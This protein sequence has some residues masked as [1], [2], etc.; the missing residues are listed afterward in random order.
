MLALIGAL[1]ILFRMLGVTLGAVDLG[2]LGLFFYGLHLA[3]GGYVASHLPW[4]PRV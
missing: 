2:W 4:G 1:C 3:F